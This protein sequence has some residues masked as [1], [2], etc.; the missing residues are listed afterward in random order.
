MFGAVSTQSLG[1]G[2]SAFPSAGHPLILFSGPQEGASRERPHQTS[3]TVLRLQSESE[4]CPLFLV[5][6]S[7]DLE[8]PNL[9][10]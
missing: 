2:F 9:L 1:Q 3:S 8:N 10:K 4:I 7:S 6:L 5:V